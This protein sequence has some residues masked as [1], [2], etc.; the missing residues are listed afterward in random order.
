MLFVVNENEPV[1]VSW[2]A[3]AEIGA[4]TTATV[5]MHASAKKPETHPKGFISSDLLL[6]VSAREELPARR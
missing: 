4:K 5:A 6:V 1:I 3:A 2:S